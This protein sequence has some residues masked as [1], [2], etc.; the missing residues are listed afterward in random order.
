MKTKLFLIATILLLLHSLQIKAQQWEYVNTLQSDGLL[1]KV[2]TQGL[3][4]VYIVGLN[5][6]IAKSTDRALTWSKQYFPTKVLLNNIIFI[7]HNIG[8]AVGANGTI[9]RTIDAGVNWTQQTSATGFNN[10]WAVGISTILRSTDGGQTW[11]KEKLLSDTIQLNDVDFYSDY[12]FIVGNYNTILKT[13]NKGDTWVLQ[14]GLKSPS[15]FAG[16]QSLCMTDHNVFMINSMDIDTIYKSTD[17]VHWEKKSPSNVLHDMTDIYFKNDT[18]GYIS[19]YFIYT[20]GSSQGKTFNYKTIDGGNNWTLTSTLE[21]GHS[22]GNFVFV[23][24]TLGYFISGKK[25]YRTPYTGKFNL[26]GGLSERKSTTQ[27]KFNQTGNNLIVTSNNELLKAFE[28]LTPAG[29]IKYYSTVNST[30]LRIDVS[31]L[32]KG[33]YLLSST[34]NDKSKEIVKWIKQ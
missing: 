23:N 11:N 3:D 12:G 34:F 22:N 8:F 20:S 32:P 27:L 26:L 13:V 2:C 1:K 6:L 4:T 25:L 18:I 7:N 16:F 14:T 30:V 28:I 9:L 15:P 24:D 33:I 5:G 19:T 21:D 31:S 29:V 17:Y 10:I